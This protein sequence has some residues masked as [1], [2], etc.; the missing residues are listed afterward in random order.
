MEKSRSYTPE[1]Q[2][3]SKIAKALAHP[4]RIAILQKLLQQTACYHGDMA[5]E[6]PIAKSTLSQ[7]LHELKSAGLIHGE[8]NL[9]SVKY[10]IHTENW[11]KARDL[12]IGLFE[13]NALASDCLC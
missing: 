12:F 5:E 9:P 13:D 8:V 7:H 3:I 1:Q 6:L 11:G 4:V 2:Q 10:C